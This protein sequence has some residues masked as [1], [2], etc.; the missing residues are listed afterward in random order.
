MTRSTKSQCEPSPN[1]SSIP[2][3]NATKD[4][5]KI[6][7]RRLPAVFRGFRGCPSSPPLHARFGGEGG[8]HLFRFWSRVFAEVR[9]PEAL[10]GRGTGSR[11]QCQ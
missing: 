9:V 5:S 7:S 10:C 3:G 1:F 8:E 11:I 6:K 2:A 4:A